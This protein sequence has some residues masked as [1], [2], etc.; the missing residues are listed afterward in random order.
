M[1]L[2]HPH[3]TCLMA[4]RPK[5]AC[6]D[7]QCAPRVPCAPPDRQLHGRSALRTRQGW[8]S[9]GVPGGPA[10]HT[11]QPAGARPRS[12][13]VQA[14]VLRPWSRSARREW[15]RHSLGASNCHGCRCPATECARVWQGDH[16]ICRWPL[17]ITRL[18]WLQ[19]PRHGLGA[20]NAV[21]LRQWWRYA[22]QGK[23]RRLNCQDDNRNADDPA[24]PA[25]GTTPP[26]LL[27]ISRRMG[28]QARLCCQLCQR[29]GRSGLGPAHNSTRCRLRAADKSAQ[30]HVLALVR[31]CLSKLCMQLS[32]DMA[33]VSARPAGRPHSERDRLPRSRSPPLT[34]PSGPAISTGSCCASEAAL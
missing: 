34:P 24:V 28:P 9:E 23:H 7:P 29:H 1:E 31:L 3:H 30:M 21:A 33:P 14:P 32:Y 13:A 16:K 10:P 5:S 15:A 26:K 11:A 19:L 22:R 2:A 8:L 20:P 27:M 17:P 6:L 4:L 18:P 12:G 25:A